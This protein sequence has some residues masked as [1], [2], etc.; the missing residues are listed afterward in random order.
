MWHYIIP[1]G[2]TNRLWYLLM[3]V[4]SKSSITNARLPESHDLNILNSIIDLPSKKLNLHVPPKW[5]S[6]AA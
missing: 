2:H 4:G 1:V 5:K 3:E 6:K